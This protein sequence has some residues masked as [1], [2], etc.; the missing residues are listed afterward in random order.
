MRSPISSASSLSGSCS[1]NTPP[2]NFL[3]RARSAAEK[4][5]PVGRPKCHSFV[6][7]VRVLGF[8]GLTRIGPRDT[9]EV[10][11]LGQEKLIVGP[12]GPGALRP[13]VDE[14][15]DPIRPAWAAAARHARIFCF[16]SHG[17]Q[18]IRQRWGRPNWPW[19]KSSRTFSRHENLRFSRELRSRDRIHATEQAVYP[20]PARRRAGR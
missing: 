16:I 11:E 14:L 6:E 1:A 4:P 5:L 12:L 13:A 17:R 9:D 8:I 20:Q 10:A 2:L 7:N 3:I 19:K 15:I 18:P